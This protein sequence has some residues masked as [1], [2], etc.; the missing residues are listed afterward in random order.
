MDKGKALRTIID[1]LE[2]VAAGELELSK[3]EWVRVIEFG[4][5]LLSVWSPEQASLLDASTRISPQ[6]IETLRSWRPRSGHTAY[7]YYLDH[8]LSIPLAERPFA[9]EVRQINEPFYRSLCTFMSRRQQSISDLFMIDMNGRDGDGDVTAQVALA[10]VYQHRERA[11]KRA[12]RLRTA[13]P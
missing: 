5:V 11:R 4:K 12:A 8:F 10:R 7:K 13:N 6:Q 9:H 1:T 3:S 2:K